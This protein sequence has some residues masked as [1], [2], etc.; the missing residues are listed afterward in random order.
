[1]TVWEAITGICALIIAGLKANESYQ[2]KKKAKQAQIDSDRIDADPAGE[3]MRVF[4]PDSAA[5]SKPSD[6]DS[7]KA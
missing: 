7:T 4:N 5:A 3:F 6:A 2:N 1:M